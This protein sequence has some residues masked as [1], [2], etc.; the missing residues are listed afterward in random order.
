MTMDRQVR[1]KLHVLNKRTVQVEDEY[2]RLD[3]RVRELTTAFLRGQP[4]LEKQ[5]R[6]LADEVENVASECRNMALAIER[7]TV[8]SYLLGEKTYELTNKVMQLRDMFPEAQLR[9]VEKARRVNRP[10]SIA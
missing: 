1:A 8:D 3:R 5:L 2:H 10:R 6:K 9:N 4:I 7:V